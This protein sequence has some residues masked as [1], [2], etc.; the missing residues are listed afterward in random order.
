MTTGR[1]FVVFNG[2]ADGLCAVVQW[3][4]HAPGPAEAVTGLKRDIALLHRVAA[5][6]GDEVD[7]FDISMQHNRRGL[8]CLLDRGVRVRYFD[9]HAAGHVPAHPGL[10]AH[11][12]ESTDVCNSL[13]VDR[14]LHGAHR[15]WALVGV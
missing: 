6:A 12:D 8:M 9:H 11:I 10:E 1:R 4:L 15:A 3:R 14:Y 13:L 5:G 7:V 2:D